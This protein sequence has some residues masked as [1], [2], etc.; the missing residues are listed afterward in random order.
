MLHRYWGLKSN[1]VFVFCFLLAGWLVCHTSRLCS[2]CVCGWA[3]Q[4]GGTLDCVF[5]TTS[6]T[7]GELVR[8]GKRELENFPI[9]PVLS[10]SLNFYLRQTFCSLGCDKSA[11]RIGNWDDREVSDGF[12]QHVWT[13]LKHLSDANSVVLRL[14]WDKYVCHTRF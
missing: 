9:Q 2:T 8:C 3:L 7:E 4:A 10:D 11:C 13:C 1:C 14:L 12:T 5:F 6:W